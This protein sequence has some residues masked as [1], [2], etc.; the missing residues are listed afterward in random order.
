[1]DGVTKFIMFGF[2]VATALMF[3]SAPLGACV[4]IV[5]IVA[6]LVLGAAG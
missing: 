5:V 4:G 6:A 3:V 2:M 1:M